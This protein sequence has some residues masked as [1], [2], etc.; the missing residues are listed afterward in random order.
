[1]H[2]VFADYHIWFCPRIAIGAESISCLHVL[3]VSFGQCLGF[4]MATRT[5]PYPMF[6]CCMGLWSVFWFHYCL[7]CTAILSWLCPCQARYPSHWFDPQCPLSLYTYIV[8]SLFI[9]YKH[10]RRGCYIHAMPEPV[11][12]QF[13]MCWPMFHPCILV[14]KEAATLGFP[15]RSD[16]HPGYLK[17]SQTYTNVVGCRLPLGLLVGYCSNAVAYINSVVSL[18]N[19]GRVAT[20]RSY[21]LQVAYTTRVV[22]LQVCGCSTPNLMGSLLAMPP[23]DGKSSA[24]KSSRGRATS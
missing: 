18:A 8:I 17:S 19:F 9:D 24:S 4:R 3:L 10:N 6:H 13:W 16:N 14:F 21:W 11:P 23:P 5:S 20:P 22:T 12:P 1:M 7:I 15:V 2:Y